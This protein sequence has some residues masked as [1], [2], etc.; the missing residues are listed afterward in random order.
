MANNLGTSLPSVRPQGRRRTLGVW[1]RVLSVGIGFLLAFAALSEIGSSS[2]VQAAP[3]PSFMILVNGSTSATISMN[4]AVTLSESGLPATA[5]GNVEVHLNGTN[6]CTIDLTGLANENMGCS[7]PR[8]Q[9]PGTFTFTAFFDNAGGL[10]ATSS[11]SATLIV[12][13]QTSFTILANIS[14]S[15][16]IAPGATA[17]L[18]EAGLPPLATG[19]LSFSANGAIIC[20]LDMTGLTYEATGCQT[21][22]SLP[23]GTYSVTATF[24]DTDGIYTGSTS[25]NSVTLTVST[26]TGFA[27]SILN[28]QSIPS[29][30]LTETANMQAT[31]SE[32]GLPPTAVG[33]VS[34]SANGSVLCTVNLTGLFEE[35]TN[36]QPTIH[37]GTVY[38]ITATFTDA[39][40][41]LLGSASS[42]SVV[43]T[44]LPWATFTISVD[45]SSS[46]TVA[47]GGSASLSEMGLPSTVT[48]TLYFYAA[49]QT[50]L[51]SVNLSGQAGEL[52]SCSTS[53]AGSYSVTGEFDD[54]DGSLGQA[55]STNSVTLTIY[56][57]TS[58]PQ[59]GGGSSP[60]P[61][62]FTVSVDGTQSLTI[63][64]SPI[65]TFGESGLPVAATGVL[66]FSA[67][68]EIVCTVGLN[69]SISELTG[70]SSTWAFGTG[71]FTVTATFTDTDGSYLG[72]TSTNAAT[73]TALPLNSTFS[74]SVNNALSATITAGGSALLSETGLPPSATGSVF[75]S[76]DGVAICSIIENGQANEPTTCLSSP[77]LVA[78]P[79]YPITA[80]FADTDGYYVSSTSTNSVTLN[81]EA[82]PSP[83]SPPG[84]TG[85]GG[86]TAQA[87]SFT[88]SV[89]N[90]SSATITAGGSTTVAEEGLPFSAT[91]SVTFRANG[92]GICSVS[93]SGL[94]D[95]PTS[96]SSPTTLGAGS[97]QVT[98]TFSDTDGNFLSSTSTNSVTLTVSS[99]SSPPAPTTSPTTS[100][101]SPVPAAN[102]GYWLVGSDGGIFTFGSAQ[103]Y[104][105]TGNLRLQR[106]VVGITPASN[107]E[108]YWLV[109]SDGGIFTFGNLNFYGSI[110]G[111]GIAPAGSG[112]SHSLNAPIVGMVPS[113]DGDGYFMVAADGGVF[114][115]GDAK[116]EGSCPGIVGGCSGAAVA[117]VPDASGN[118]Y[119][120]VTATGHVYAFG[121]A[122][123]HGAPGPQAVPVTAAVRTI[124]GGGYW[125]LF[126]N[127]VVAPYGDA[128]NLGGP[129]GSVNGVDPAT[130]IFTTSDGDGYW[131]TTATGS[132]FTQGDAPF[133]GSMSGVHLN[134][135]IVA[136]TGW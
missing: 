7:T 131:V 128:A 93:L 73:V 78:S 44:V 3:P 134:G 62:S 94:A 57:E 29:S 12:S 23:V 122:V 101:P 21:P 100:T 118:G 53:L 2:A 8:M 30:A 96:C 20:T 82:A 55:P 114:A 121:D 60:L 17:L 75:F 66:T 52:T 126:S 35:T 105:S 16:T 115:F 50:L 71:I 26:E 80:T 77:S 111:L 89:N 38:S 31:L 1:R 90:A 54:T 27:I 102:D 79:Y 133:D 132:V 28:D 41:V 129:V 18:S 42:N 95:E 135:S 64:K 87:T 85:G 48:G 40:G 36:C 39:N 109:A 83:P 99:Q 76:V 14:T 72:S 110:P 104:G 91:G 119:W 63:T 108:G 125:L 32:N 33:T 51:C 22:L 127:G 4:A 10:S 5:T 61:T 130:A 45:N 112:L 58:P 11:N 59:G 24:S 86:S 43:L 69:G 9:S 97:Y 107:D 70:C 98:A 103:F 84:G 113:A 74:I 92:V 123:Y 67:N 6:I 15:L 49:N 81:V 37:A 106:P 88:I 56:P 65:V 124:D 68:G 47:A 19:P 136:A 46:A 120:L 34:F 25:S 117:V 116:F 13:P